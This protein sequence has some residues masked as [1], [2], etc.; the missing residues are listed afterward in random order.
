VI[1][2]RAKLRDRTKEI[3]LEV[4]GVERISDEDIEVLDR[5]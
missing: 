4:E 1:E 2:T 5:I 3:A